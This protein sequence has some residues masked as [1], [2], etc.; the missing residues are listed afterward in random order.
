MKDFNALKKNLKKDF[1]GLK[2][3]KLAILGDSDEM[4]RG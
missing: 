4:L 2:K 1:S 3:I